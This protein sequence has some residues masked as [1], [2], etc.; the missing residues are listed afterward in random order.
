MGRLSDSPVYNFLG[1]AGYKIDARYSHFASVKS[2]GRVPKS[3]HSPVISSTKTYPRNYSSVKIDLLL[4]SGCFCLFFFQFIRSPFINNTMICI[5]VAHVQVK[6]RHGISKH[7]HRRNCL[8]KFNYLRWSTTSIIQKSE[9][10]LKILFSRNINIYT[11][12]NH[13]TK[14]IFLKQLECVLIFNILHAPL[15]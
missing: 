4:I 2:S 5:Y 15:P 3:V 11:F 6:V 14:F 12:K 1:I 8:E 13:C 9:K 7:G 10:I